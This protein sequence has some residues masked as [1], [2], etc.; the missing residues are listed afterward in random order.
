M[1]HHAKNEVKTERGKDRIRE[2]TVVICF[3]LEN[4]FTLLKCGVSSF[5]YK[6]KL[7]SYNLIA[8]TSL[9]LNGV[10]TNKYYS[11]VWTETRL[12]NLKLK[13]LGFLGF[14]KKPKIFKKYHF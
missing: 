4:I 12:E 2:G 14:L 8:H 6:R 7:T 1:H 11:C 3:D 10:Q 5:F 9:H 13:N